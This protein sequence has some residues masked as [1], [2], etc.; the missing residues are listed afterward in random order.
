MKHKLLFII[1]TL[2]IILIQRQSI[3]ITVTATPNPAVV[4]QNVVVNI[5]A[6]FKAG[7]EVPHCPIEANFGDGSPWVDVGTCTSSPC[8]LSTYHAYSVPGIY[9]ITAR[10]KTMCKM[11]PMSPDPATTSITIQCPPISITSPSILPTGTIGQSYSYQLQTSGGQ[12]P[13]A[14]TITSGS[15]PPG[16]SLGLTGLISGTPTTAGTFSFTVRATDS[17]KAGMQSTQ[18]AFSLTINFIRFNKSKCPPISITSPSILPTGTIGQSYSYQL[19]TSGGQPPIAYTITSGSL[20]PGLSLGLTGLI[21]GTPTTAGTFSFTVRATDSCKAGM[22]STQKAF[23]LTITPASVTVSEG[24]TVSVKVTPPFFRISRGMVSTQG[25]SYSFSAVPPVNMRL[26][27]TS[28]VFRAGGNVIGEVNLPLSVEIRNGA[29][30]VSEVLT[31]PVAIIKRAER[32]KT[33]RITYSRTFSDGGISITAQVRIV[34]TTEAGAELSITRFQLYFK[35]RRAEITVKRNQ[36]SLK[37]YADIRFTGSGFLQGYWEVD[38]RIVKNVFKHLVYG[39]SVTI[40]TLDAPSLPT[41]D[42]GT[43]IVRFV[44]TKPTMQI[45]LPEALYFVTNEEFR[46]PLIIRLISPDNRSEIAYSPISFSWEDKDKTIVYLIEFYGKDSH[47]PVF[48]AYTKSTDYKL[49][50][51][52][53]KRIF[54]PGKLYAWQVKGFDA[55]NNIIAE[56]PI[57]QFTFKKSIF[58]F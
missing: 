3:A 53:L 13:I 46:G 11:P 31:I 15:L 27:S 58:V 48:S 14:Y 10:S 24:V 9:L 21:S 19:Q 17:C 5:N 52:V 25:L 32:L 33:S 26:R 34:V 54:S 20:P 57:Y 37:A 16:L 29:G 28:G 40:E 39:R 41:F 35:N 51:I 49:P 1:V 8:I 23:S 50:K 47:K 2:F 6:I 30:S 18:K 45:P 36:P 7:S 42:P 38:G 44:V 4:N 43:H 56:S 55:E 12:P 22:Q